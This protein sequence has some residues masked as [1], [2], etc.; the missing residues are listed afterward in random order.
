[1]GEREIKQAKKEEKNR[2]KR[3][4]LNRFE[5]WKV[6]TEEIFPRMLNQSAICGF[7]K[8]TGLKPSEEGVEDKICFIC[9]WS[10]ENHG[11]CSRTNRENCDWIN[12]IR[13]SI[14]RE[15]TGEAID[16]L[17]L[18]LPMAKGYASEHN[19]GSNR[20]YVQAVEEFLSKL[21]GE[22]K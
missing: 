4:L 8:G 9:T 20:K 17:G 13:Q 18:I 14:E 15:T 5:A 12:G 22:I 21:K 2:I 10:G 19:V 7:C 6:R 16:L 3:R 1:M 11:K